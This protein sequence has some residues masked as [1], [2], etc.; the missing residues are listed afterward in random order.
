MST[1]SNPNNEEDEDIPEIDINISNVVS[2]FR[3][4]CHLNLRQIAT[5]GYNVVY[6]REQGVR[7]VYEYCINCFPPMN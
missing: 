4:R 7:Y 3:T 1:C 6:K 2:S 5:N